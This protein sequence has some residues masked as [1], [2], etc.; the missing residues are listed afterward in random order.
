MKRLPIALV[1][2][3]SMLAM[4]VCAEEATTIKIN[5]SL[6]VERISPQPTVGVSTHAFTIVLSGG[7]QIHERYVGGG[8][9]SLDINREATM[10]ANSGQHFE[11]RVVNANTIAMTRNFESYVQV[12]TI[13]VTGKSC[14]ISYNATLKPGKTE[15]VSYSQELGLMATYR[16]FRLADS[17]CEIG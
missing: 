1:S 6:S 12:I 16:Y 15:F 11:Y 2:M 10:G 17:S 3:A 9:H 13:Y 7:N 14:H 8:K 4:G 5:F